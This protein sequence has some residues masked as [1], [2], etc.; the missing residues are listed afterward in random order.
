LSKTLTTNTVEERNKQTKSR[1]K[2]V[3]GNLWVTQNCC[4]IKI[5]FS[6][7]SKQRCTS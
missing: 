2:E 6:W 5:V 7:W 3:F 4:D 1:A